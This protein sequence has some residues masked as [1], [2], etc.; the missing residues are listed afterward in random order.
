MPSELGL[1]AAHL[2]P[3]RV[4]VM[5]AGKVIDV[6]VSEHDALEVTRSHEPVLSFV[7]ASLQGITIW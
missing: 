4:R 3:R 6:H 1:L 5:Q 2:T 7:S